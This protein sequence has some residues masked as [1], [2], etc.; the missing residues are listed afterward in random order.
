MRWREGTDLHHDDDLVSPVDRP[1][2]DLSARRDAHAEAWRVEIGRSFD[3]ESSLIAFGRRDE[4]DVVLKVVR[5]P[6]D[7]WRSGEIVRAFGG[8]GMVR[9]LEHA[10]GAVLLERLH[11]GTS[12]TERV[13]SGNDVEATSIIADVIATMRPDAPPDGC[14]TVEG[15]GRSFARYRESGDLRLPTDLVADAERVYAHLCATQRSTRLLHGDLQHYNV[16]HDNA[17]GWVTIDPKGVVGEL[18]YELGAFMRNPTE[19][20]SLFTDVAIASRR[21]RQVTTALGAD[22]E[23]ATAWSYAQA[24]L[25]VIWGIEDGFTVDPSHPTL[26]LARALRPLVG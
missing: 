7:E 26:A 17:R 23:R 12:L 5:S 16:L 2:A 8:R 22:I 15:W 1:T 6:G 9:A 3:T 19:H 14:A 21:L 18:E 4:Q 11:P 24:V 20:P 13:V 10:E 25:S